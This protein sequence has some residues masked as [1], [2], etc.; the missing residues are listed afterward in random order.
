MLAPAAAL[1]LMIVSGAQRD[2]P[3]APRGDAEIYVR[4]ALGLSEFGVLGQYVGG[5][6]PPQPEAEVTPLYPLLLAGLFLIDDDMRQS[7]LC[8]AR[9]E[10]GAYCPRDYAPLVI[11]QT[12]LMAGLL[13]TVWATALVWT[14]RFAIGWLAMLAAWVSGAA[15]DFTHV[16]LTEA[17]TLPLFGLFTFLT[18]MIIRRRSPSMAAAGAGAVLGML[19]LT[20]PSFWYLFLFFLLALVVLSSNAGL[21]RR[22]ARWL[23][24]MCG[25]CIVLVAVWVGRNYQHF[26]FPHVSGGGYAG[27]ALAQRV[28]YNDMRLSEI[29]AAFVFWLP[30]FGDSLARALLP[31]TA[32]Q[33]LGWGKGSIYEKAGEFS[34]RTLLVAGGPEH[35]VG[36]LLR[37]EILAAPFKHAMVT[38]VLAWRG[39][40]IEKYWGLFG[41]LCAGLLYVRSWRAREPGFLV[42]TLPPLFMVMFHAAVSISVPRYNVVLLPVLALAIAC[43][44]HLWCGRLW[45][46]RATE[47]QREPGAALAG[48]AIDGDDD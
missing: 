2:A 13:L 40:F 11:V 3:L 44:L 45:R 10:M 38:V 17:L 5:Q 20:R 37:H 35:H 8:V 25:V 19:V 42:L 9:D 23:A 24:L 32:I 7:A 34:A 14:D 27:R 26:G 1:L 21:R 48:R 47:P 39:L 28:G 15:S 33:R 31:E 41:W 22:A 36:Y 16:P 12:L 43:Q 46:H 6:T 18:A 30:D 29:G 4:L